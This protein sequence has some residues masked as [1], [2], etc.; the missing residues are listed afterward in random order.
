MGLTLMLAVAA[1]PPLTD[2]S[3]SNA[4]ESELFMDKAVP[5]YRIEVSTIE[6]IVTLTG[7]VDN[8]P[9]K[10]RAARIAQI[11]KGVRAVVNEIEV[12][13]PVLRTDWEIREDVEDALITDPATDKYE[14]D[15]S[16]QGNVVTLSGTVDSWVEYNAAANNAYEGGAVYVANDLIVN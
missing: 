15:V 14:I 7:S 13:P 4:L 5:S 3:N 9:A 11:V 8:I 12:D 6:G 2:R 10:E 1:E 16:V